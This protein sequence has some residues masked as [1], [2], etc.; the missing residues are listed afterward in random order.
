[1][2]QFTIDLDDILSLVSCAPTYGFADEVFYDAMA[3]WMDRTLSDEEI[4][5]Q[6]RSFLEPEM[7]AKGYGEED[8]QE[9]RERLAAF[10]NR[11]C[12]D[13]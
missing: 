4:E 6:A 5:D 10:K 11:Y 7:V 2:R 12:P 13:G 9:V 3:S 8:A 1:M